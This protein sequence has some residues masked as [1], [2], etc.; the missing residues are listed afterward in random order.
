MRATLILKQALWELKR[1]IA[2]KYWHCKRHGLCHNIRQNKLAL[3]GGF[4]IGG[5]YTLLS[6]T[7][8]LKDKQGP[9][10]FAWYCYGSLP[11]PFLFPGFV[12][13]G[14]IHCVDFSLELYN[15]VERE[16]E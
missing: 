8:P 11:A 7:D 16:Y 12:F 1:E 9:E 15:K 2:W 14:F 3:Y 4:T 10:R 13:L 6:I 5:A